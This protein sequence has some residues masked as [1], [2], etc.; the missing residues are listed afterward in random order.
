MTITSVF[1]AH[2]AP[3]L[4]DHPDRPSPDSP[5]PDNSPPGRETP[6]HA[7]PFADDWIGDTDFGEENEVEMDTEAEEESKR[8]REEHPRQGKPLE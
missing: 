2:D 3:H 1:F 7:A 5:P 4:E 6:S 8:D